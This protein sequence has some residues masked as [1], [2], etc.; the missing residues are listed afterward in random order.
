MDDKIFD[1]S[2]KE[3]NAVPAEGFAEASAAEESAAAGGAPEA[4][5]EKP[6]Y[7]TVRAKLAYTNAGGALLAFIA[8]IQVAAVVISLSLVAFESPLLRT[9]WISLAVNFVCIYCIA[10]PI[11]YL[12]VRKQPVHRPPEKKLS[13]WGFVTVCVISVACIFVINY[14]TN[15]VITLLNGGDPGSSDLDQLLTQSN[16]W[17]SVLFTVVFAPFFEELVFRR[18]LC[19]RLAV[20]GEWQAVLFSS[21]AFGLFHTNVRQIPYAFV[22]GCLFGIVYVRTGR[23]RY[24]VLLHAV[25]N[26]FGS[27]PSL[28]LIKAGAVEQIAQLVPMLSEDPVE[29]FKF[30][31]EHP[32]VIGMLVHSMVMLTLSVVG[33]A[34]AIAFCKRLIRSTDAALMPRKSRF[35]IM[36]SGVFPILFILLALYLTFQRGI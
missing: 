30:M 7:P 5:E 8:V 15:I 12:I 36:F 25:V 34:L 29:A 2:P 32:A 26:F 13:F 4:E 33:I 20:Y 28:V 19:D 24:T 14:V 18:L 6:S 9:D 3:E 23:L 16:F 11:F 1:N 17:L 21:L 22:L 35:Y 31:A 27:V 10:V